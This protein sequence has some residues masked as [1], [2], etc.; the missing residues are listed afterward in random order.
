MLEDAVFAVIDERAAYGRWRHPAEERGC[1][2]AARRAE[3]GAIVYERY[4]RFK[5]VRA[6]CHHKADVRPQHKLVVHLQPRLADPG[7]EERRAHASHNRHEAHDC[8]GMKGAKI[9]RAHA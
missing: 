6:G 2:N 4:E 9:G 8:T 3:W 5:E 1:Q 7:A